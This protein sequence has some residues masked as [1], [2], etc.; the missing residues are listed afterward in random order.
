MPVAGTGLPDP[1][2]WHEVVRTHP[3]EPHTNEWGEQTMRIRD[4]FSYSA[5][6]DSVGLDCAYCVHF[7]GPSSWPDTDRTSRCRLHAIPLDIGLGRC[8]YKED[9][10][11]CRD[12][13]DDGRAHGTA[14]EEFEALKA[15]LQSETLYGAYGLRGYLKEIEFKRLR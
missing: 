13:S 12:F 5:R 11:F 2:M 4:P 3:H 15:G 10:W 9:E 14:V 7:A 6:W 8:G 1:I